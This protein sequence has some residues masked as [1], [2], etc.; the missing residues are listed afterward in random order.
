MIMV[1]RR[2]RTSKFTG[3]ILPCRQSRGLVHS[4]PAAAA[5][6]CTFLGDRGFDYWQDV[7]LRGDGVVQNGDFQPKLLPKWPLFLTP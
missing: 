7:L 2:T 3:L 6:G 5:V 1:V 4:C